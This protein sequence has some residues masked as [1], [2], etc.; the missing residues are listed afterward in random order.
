MMSAFRGFFLCA[1][2][3]PRALLRIRRE[4]GEFCNHFSFGPVIS[5]Q[6][7]RRYGNFESSQIREGVARSALC[8]LCALQ[9]FLCSRRRS[10]RRFFTASPTSWQRRRTLWTWTRRNVRSVESFRFAIPGAGRITTGLRNSRL[11]I[12]ETGTS[13]LSQRKAHA[14]S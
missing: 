10:G 3:A 5:V 4:C 2:K 12:A 13:F 11:R 14:L 8:W 6:R 9:L 1:F 7:V